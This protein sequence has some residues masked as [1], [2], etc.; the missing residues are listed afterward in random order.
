MKGGQCLPF[1]FYNLCM[2][3]T[4]LK[5]FNLEQT[6]KRLSTLRPAM[7]INALIIDWI[8]IISTITIT[9]TFFN[10]LLYILAVM[11]IGGRMHALGIMSH[12]VVHYRFLPNRKLADIIGN[13][14]MTWP[15]FYTVPG[16]RSMHLRHH[17]KLNT[18]EDPDWVRRRGKDEWTFP[19]SEN[20]LMGIMAK[21]VSGFNLY[22]YIMKVFVLPKKDKK[23]KKD[24]DSLPVTYYVAM[25]LFYITLFTVITYFGVWKQYLI[26]WVIPIFTWLKFI[27]RVRAV[28]EHFAI[29]AGKRDELTRTVI[30]TFFERI[31]VAPKGINYHI[32]HHRYP[33]VPWY[34][35]EEFHHILQKQ[36]LLT[37]MG[38]VT[39]G[40]LKGVLREARKE[41]CLTTQNGA[42][43]KP[44]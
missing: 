22:Q 42:S 20:K 3:A 28:A 16:F 9:E 29:P 32:E 33:G 15:L 21:D 39:D 38:H 13:I 7:A 2:N 6:V 12:D 8:I 25:A 26:Y 10:P 27:K 19:M 30:P 37:Q 14:F 24:F 1:L 41:C 36:G 35:L 17:S 43:P 44:L 23:L 11:I 5:P 18:D 4:T 34:H 31:F 40:Y